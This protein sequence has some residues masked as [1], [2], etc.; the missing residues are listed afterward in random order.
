MKKLV[1]AGFIAIFL[2]SG[3][4]A[5]RSSNAPCTRGATRAEIELVQVS[6]FYLCGDPVEVTFIAR[7][8]RRISGRP[9]PAEFVGVMPCPGEQFQAGY[10][11][12]GCIGEPASQVPYRRLDAFRTDL[13]PRLY[14]RTVAWLRRY[15]HR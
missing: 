10:R 7:V 1:F 9:V 2:V 8:V 4:E 14:T 11:F 13:R 5:Q 15:P 12:E 6:R 3:A